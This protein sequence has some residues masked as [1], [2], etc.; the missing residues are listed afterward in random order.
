MKPFDDYPKGGYTILPK[1]RGGNARREYG[2][3]LVE[4]GQ[5]SC[6]YCGTSLVDSY[7]HWLL[8]T[9][10]HVIPATEGRRLGIPKQ[11]RESYSNIVLACFGCS[12]FSNRYEVSWQDPKY[13]WDETEF[14]ELRDRVF[15]E[16]AD[17]IEEA[18]NSEMSFYNDRV[19]WRQGRDAR[20]RR[21]A[22]GGLAWLSKGQTEA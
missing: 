3:W 4:N 11:W 20:Y 13:Y 16:K 2:Y 6:V 22:P 14:F 8:L 10:S 18:R 7:E 1:L 15:E 12:G 19:A 9:A 21:N 5:T 17:L